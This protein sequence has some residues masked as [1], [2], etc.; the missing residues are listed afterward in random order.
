MSVQMRNSKTI[1]PIDLIFYTRSIISMVMTKTC[2]MTSLY[3][4]IIARDGL[5]SMIALSYI[6]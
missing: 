4:C 3:M 6:E 1:A 5:S 2:V